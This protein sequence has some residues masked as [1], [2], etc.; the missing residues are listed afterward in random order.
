M[1]FVKVKRFRSSANIVACEVTSHSVADILVCKV[2]SEDIAN[3]N[4]HL[5]Y[6]VEL[7]SAAN[8]K[9]CFIKSRP[10]ADL[11]VCYVSSIDKAGWVKHNHPLKGKIG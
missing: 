1:A 2:E 11:L 3:G 9:I 7:D 5:W 8:S 10:V 6:F 4:D